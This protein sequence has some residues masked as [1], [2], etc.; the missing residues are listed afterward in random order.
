M[1]PVPLCQPSEAQ[2]ETISLA[3]WLSHSQTHPYTHTSGRQE[4]LAARTSPS[5][6]L[7]EPSASPC[8]P[9]LLPLLFLAQLR[10]LL[11]PQGPGADLFMAPLTRSLYPA[12]SQSCYE[13]GEGLRSLAE[14]RSFAQAV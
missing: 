14:P 3:I 2:G 9:N 6:Q 4:P 13:G 1:M 10:P 7:A 11:G 12:R 5:T 8:F